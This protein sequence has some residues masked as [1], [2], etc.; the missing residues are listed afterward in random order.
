M[1]GRLVHRLRLLLVAGVL[2]AL[3]PLLLRSGLGLL[4]VPPYAVVGAILVMRRPNNVIGW[5]V[6]A[7]G[8]A[9]GILLIPSIDAT[10]AQF[11]DGSAPPVEAVLAVLTAGATG[12]ALFLILF[13]LALVFPSGRWPGGRRGRT[14][15]WVVGIASALTLASFLRPEITVQLDGLP[16]PIP[17]HNPLSILPGLP[18]WGVIDPNIL[19]LPLFV[20]ILAGVI[21]LVVRFGRAVGV[22]RQQLR[23]VVAAVAFLAIAMTLGFTLPAI[24]PAIGDSGG[25]W[26]P[27][28]IAYPCVPI[29]I[30]IAV[31]RYRLYEIDRIISR[32]I[33]W[34]LTTG[35]V[36]GL[37]AGLIVALQAMLAPV[38]DQNSLA[39]AGSTLAA[40]ALFQPIRRRVQSAVDH[41]FNRSRY[42]AERIVGGFAANLRGETDLRQIGDE[43]ADAVTRSL[44][45]ASVSVWMRRRSIEP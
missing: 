3:V 5:L 1:S 22:E 18:I 2:L 44:R 20:L 6:F 36:A 11:A 25:N 19:T 30:G 8:A 27:A 26:I 4:V 29:A 14:L 32:T 40:A 39:V 9:F 33:S 42:D 43:V 10:A 35:L 12:M 28:L 7:A 23:W 17:V 38:T 45:P 41:R 13:V 34:T 31:L 16:A 37:F 21:S 15:R 24:A